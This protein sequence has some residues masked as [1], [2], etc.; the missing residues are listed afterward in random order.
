MG[1][2]GQELREEREARHISIEEIASS[3]KIVSR[4]LEAL[5]DDRLDIMPGGF[6]IR[7]IIR[8]YAKAVG[9]DPEQ[10]LGRYKAAGLLG[11]PE[12]KR[13]IFQ[14]AAPGP[15]PP[16]PPPPGPTPPTEAPRA[17]SPAPFPPAPESPATPPEPAPAPETASGLLIEP[18]PKPRLSPAARKTIIGWIWRSALV[19][20]A[21]AIL[22]LLWSSRRP[23]PPES[24]PGSVTSKA[25][26]AGGPL[27]PVAAPAVPIEPPAPIEEAWKGVTI[28]IAFRDATWIRVYA[29]GA[30]QIDGL[31]PAG[32]TARAR[33]D[34]RI[35]LTTG[36]AGGFTFLLNGEPARS[37]GRAGDL[38]TDITITPANYKEFL[39]PRPPGPPAG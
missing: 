1:S 14:R 7:G 37:L 39:E 2:L 25:V 36:N 30:L 34:D 31:F 16:L 10:V 13:T 11:E 32:A 22:V 12:P 17:P 15:A 3:T 5:E 9:L 26:P 6:F 27:P 33:A 4:Y 24:K 38:L 21:V 23:R 18:A 19:L 28:E 20:I 29:D 35:V 8:A